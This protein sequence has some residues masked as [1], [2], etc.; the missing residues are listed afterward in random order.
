MSVPAEQL[1]KQ[2]EQA[3]RSVGIPPRPAIL[4]RL[5]RDLRADD[6]DFGKIGE[7]IGGDAALAAAMLKTV[8][9]AAFGLST[10]A[11]SVKHALAI[12]GMRTAG[13]LVTGLLLRQAFPVNSHPLMERFW[14]T[15]SRIAALSM[16]IACE[17]RAIDP[18]AAHTLGL[19]RDCGMAVM[20]SK[21]PEYAAVVRG[22]SQPDAPRLTDSEN[23]QFEV[24]H[25]IIGQVMATDWMLPA[26]VCDAVLHHHSPDAHRGRRSDLHQD[27]M[28]LIA[29]T[30][31]ADYTCAMAEGEATSRDLC[32]CA[33]FA[34]LQLGL[35]AAGKDR[36]ADLA[37][38]ETAAT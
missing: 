26:A 1:R 30:T 5:I 11:S 4:T 35:G 17:T 36:F 21:Y 31:L 14:E 9:S 15:S 37:V 27:T 13:S 16:R 22:A 7:L 6:P 28:R 12:L 38:E 33:D 34:A 2:A 18:D 29:V 25:A 10:R 32:M 24:N 19:F 20:L 23:L 3:V 8:N